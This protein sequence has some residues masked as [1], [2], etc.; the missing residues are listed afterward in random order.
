MDLKKK[1]SEISPTRVTLTHVSPWIGCTARWTLALT[2]LLENKGA[3]RNRWIS[4]GNLGECLRWR[5]H[6]KETMDIR[7]EFA[8]RRRK[9]D[10]GELTAWRPP[11]FLFF[12][13]LRRTCAT[14]SEATGPNRSEDAGDGSAALFSLAPQDVLDTGRNHVFVVFHHIRTRDRVRRVLEPPCLLRAGAMPA[15]L[16]M[17]RRGIVELFAR[18]TRVAHVAPKILHKQRV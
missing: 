7:Q 18:V 15:D 1:T 14:S 16:V 17:V 2:T 4:S 5:L 3:A 6:L 11:K 12:F 9:S 8:R 13:G 10:A